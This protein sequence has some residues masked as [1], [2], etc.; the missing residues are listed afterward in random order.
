MAGGQPPK[1]QSSAR[2]TGFR[3]SQHGPKLARAVNGALSRAGAK[4]KAYVSRRTSGKK[5]V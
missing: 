4:V 1:R 3:R 2:K 5:K